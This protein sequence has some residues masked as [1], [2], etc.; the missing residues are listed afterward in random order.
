[1]RHR[2][3]FFLPFWLLLRYLPKVFKL[4]PPAVRRTHAFLVASFYARYH[5]PD[6]AQR[7]VIIEKA[8][9]MVDYRGMW[10]YRAL[11]HI[12][13][14]GI[15]SREIQRLYETDSFVSPSEYNVIDLSLFTTNIALFSR[16]LA[17]TSTAL[18]YV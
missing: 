11:S 1:M 13:A 12:H 7:R 6:V 4:G 3:R 18:R 16:A 17:L 8:I 9:F 10:S 15:V 14:D 5:T 2:T